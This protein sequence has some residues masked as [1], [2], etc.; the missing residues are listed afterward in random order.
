VET[1]PAP[2]AEP[3]VEEETAED[4]GTELTVENLAEATVKAF[5]AI[6]A[7]RAAEA[8]QTADEAD[9]SDVE[10]RALA[11]QRENDQLK[12]A[13]TARA[14]REEQQKLAH[15]VLSTAGKLKMTDA[16]CISVGTFFER[17]PEYFGVWSFE[18]AALH[19]FPEL[20]GRLATAPPA[21]PPS[22]APGNGGQATGVVPAGTGG[23]ATPQ[24]F[25]HNG[26]RF[27]YSDVTRAVLASGEAAKLG[28]YV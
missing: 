28:S 5:E 11:L 6:E 10:R 24:P 20:K 23:P 3:E 7:K 19:V 25:K 22:A 18:R 26:R 2:P 17:N 14:E 8:K 15:E 27:D 1:P 4:D 16:E 13:E 12:A 21:Q 9:L